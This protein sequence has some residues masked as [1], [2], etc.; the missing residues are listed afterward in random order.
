MSSKCS[1]LTIKASKFN[2]SIT[3]NIVIISELLQLHITTHNGHRVCDPVSL[4]PVLV[5]ARGEHFLRRLQTPPVE[6]LLTATGG[7]HR[8]LEPVPPAP[9]QSGQQGHVGLDH[10]LHVGLLT[11]V[12]EYLDDLK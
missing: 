12:L 11:T 9:H 1:Q 10:N 3:T 6:T 5:N 4:E 7:H 8:N 2:N